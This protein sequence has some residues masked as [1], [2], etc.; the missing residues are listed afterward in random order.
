MTIKSSS[1]E[2]QKQQELKQSVIEIFMQKINNLSEETI[3]KYQSIF[4][5]IENGNITSKTFNSILHLMETN[6]N[7]EIRDVASK[8][9]DD[10]NRLMVEFKKQAK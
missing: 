9:K 7:Q 3:K 6:E 5:L 2:T 4:S 10:I 8:I 1:Q